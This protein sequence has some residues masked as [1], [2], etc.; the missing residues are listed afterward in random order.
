MFVFALK[1]EIGI[2]TKIN[3]HIRALRFHCRK[4]VISFLKKT[5]F[6]LD[7]LERAPTASGGL[8]NMSKEEIQR[9]AARVQRDQ[10][11][12]PRLPET[13]LAELDFGLGLKK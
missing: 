12:R 3:T 8:R 5:F 7:D 1:H 11:R 6:S 4:I 13:C 2:K 10:A 9:S